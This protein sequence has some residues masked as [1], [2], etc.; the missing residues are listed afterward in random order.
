MLFM[1][2]PSYLGNSV[3]TFISSQFLSSRIRR[4]EKLFL[5]L[6]FMGQVFSELPSQN[7]GKD[8]CEVDIS[9]PLSAV[10]ITI[11]ELFIVS[12]LL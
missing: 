4:R 5:V 3:I 8:S 1:L 2:C 12:I 10:T 9:L 7:A 11:I 6:K